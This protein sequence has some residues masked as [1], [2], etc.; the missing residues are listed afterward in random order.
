V[1]L[2][3]LRFFCR[4]VG[5]GAL[6]LEKL[7]R[8]F[9]CF[10]KLLRHGLLF[11]EDFRLP[12]FLDGRRVD[13]VGCSLRHHFAISGILFDQ[14]AFNLFHLPF[15]S[16]EFFAI[17]FLTA[18]MHYE[19]VASLTL[20]V[21]DNSFDDLVFLVRLSFIFFKEFE[22]H[23]VRHNYHLTGKKILKF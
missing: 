11:F 4:F 7:V 20:E 5:F 1:E 16:E 15:N 9:F 8:L 18:K 6:G 19:L 14:K 22:F 12:C 13:L 3:S 21:F 2:V 23:L 17:I 10:P